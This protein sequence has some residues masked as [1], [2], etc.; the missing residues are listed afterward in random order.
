MLLLRSPKQLSII[1]CVYAG[2]LEERV[3]RLP[4]ARHSVW[5]TGSGC[6]MGMRLNEGQA[7]IRRS[8]ADN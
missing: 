1:W 4:L 7:T 2:T 8:S 6:Q 5:V 3:L